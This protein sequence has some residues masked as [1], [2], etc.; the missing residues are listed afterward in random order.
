[1]TPVLVLTTWPSSSP[2][3]DFV[4]HLVQRK[5]AACVNV[6]PGIVS[7]FFW[8]GQLERES[9]QLLLIKTVEEKLNGI[10]QMFAEHHPYEVPE[11]LVLPIRQ[12]DNPY[13]DWLIH[14]VRDQQ[15]N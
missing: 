6:L 7:V 5:L 11:L 1:M 8:Q 12:D 3:D 14:S 9:E 15:A 10:R 13:L 4:T 2:C